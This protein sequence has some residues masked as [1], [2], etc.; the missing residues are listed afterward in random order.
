MKYNKEFFQFLKDMDDVFGY[1]CRTSRRIKDFVK[2]YEIHD[3]K[4]YTMMQDN[5]PDYNSDHF[6]VHGR[7]NNTGYDL[8]KTIEKVYI[9]SG[10]G[11][12]KSSLW[13]LIND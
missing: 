12:F 11:I 5:D 3:D 13:K 7:P 10:N 4:F 2:V 9:H 8:Y 6:T 1:D